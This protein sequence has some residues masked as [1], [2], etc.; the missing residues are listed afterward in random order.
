MIPKVIHQTWRANEL[1]ELFQKVYEY[2]K[3]INSNFEFKL[4][5]H[6]P[7]N[8]DIENLIKEKFTDIFPIYE[9]CKMGVQKADIGRLAILYEYGG[10]YTD[11]DILYLKSFDD[12]IDYNSNNIY[13]ALE[14]EEQTKKVF[15]SSNVLCNAF[16]M[17]PPKHD[18][19]KKTLDN[20]KL[21]YVKY[22]DA[23]FTKFN[24]FGADLL[25]FT[26]SQDEYFNYVKFID[27]KL[28]YPI[29]D[30]K[31]NDL[32]TTKSDY[33]MLKKGDY[34]NSYCVHYWIHSDFE[35]KE[36][37]E[38]YRFNIDKNIH[39]NIYDFFRKLYPD[40]NI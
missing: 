14:P 25:S 18:F 32:P 31:F 21:L 22:G 10:I 33:E 29:N 15:N 37:I 7:A 34:N 9:K 39:Q 19:F 17:T 20:I 26:M 13:M 6:E 27:R 1:P 3:E 40:K 28:I 5:T 36:L 16:I 35:S 8:P 24:F 30:P 38:I 4:W 2:N 23:I 12:L 11:L